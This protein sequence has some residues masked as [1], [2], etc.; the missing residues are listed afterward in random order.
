MP[1][2]FGYWPIKGLGGFNRLVAKHLGVEMT[3]VNPDGQAWF[4]GE[5]FNVGLDFPNL[6]YLIDGDF[7]LSEHAAINRY[8]ADST[9]NSDFFGANTQDKA[10]VE[11]VMSVTHDILM[12]FFMNAMNP[13]FKDML[14]KSVDEKAKIPTK[15][16]E[17][18]KMLGE[19]DWLV[20]NTMSIADIKLAY[21]MFLIGHAYDSLEIANPFK[22]H[23]NLVDLH[24][25]V[26]GLDT[27]KDYV[28][29]PQWVNAPFFP[30]SHF[31]WVKMPG[32]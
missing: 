14:A 7:K 13:Q 6:P 1:I 17:L 32:A 16:G 19:N 10:R 24:A 11:M 23:Q 12:D 22:V 8:L 30:P 29:S 20:S 26:W 31:P 28:A 15:L 18:S 3:E 4:G 21:F 2:T 27:L 25:R 9:G 5:K